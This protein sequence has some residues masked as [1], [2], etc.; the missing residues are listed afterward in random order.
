M[1]F[2]KSFF[3]SLSM[4]TKIP[5]F[6]VWDEKSKKYMLLTFP[7]V[8]LIIGLI[9]YLI[10]YLLNLIHTP[11]IILA[12]ALS[13]YSL[14]ITGGIHFDG[15]MD[16]VDAKSSYKPLEERLKILKD[17]HVGA[18]A[19]IWSIVIIL[20]HFVFFY[21]LKEDT[22]YLFLVFLPIIS[23]IMSSLSLTTFKPLSTSQ[24][25]NDGIKEHKGLRIA[26]LCILLA[27][28]LVV[29]YLFINKETFIFLGT[30]L[31]H[32]LCTILCRIN[33]KGVNGDVCGYSLS[34]AEVLTILVLVIGELT[35]M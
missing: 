8:G 5:T 20:A 16:V 3:M 7:F 26:Y 9:W 13:I 2:I 19:V 12:F 31:V 24:Y 15:F 1:K 6:N 23:R 14:I 18:F 27:I 28:T 10:A 17:S 34:I 11:H 21:A 29:S 33:L 4:F 22:N 25:N 32:L 35:W 30:I